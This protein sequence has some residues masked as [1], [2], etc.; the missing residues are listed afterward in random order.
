MNQFNV[1]LNTLLLVAIL[2][3][4]VWN[5]SRGRQRFQA[6]GDS[7]DA[8]LDTYWT[9]LSSQQRGQA[10]P[11]AGTKFLSVLLGDKVAAP[12]NR[13]SKRARMC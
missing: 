9:G 13:R 3:A 5:G 11:A 6:L 7:E 8:A 12:K 1:R 2:A 4:L 10:H